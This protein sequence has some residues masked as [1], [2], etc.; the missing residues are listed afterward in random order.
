MSR[1]PERVAW[2]NAKGRCFNPKNPKY[3]R[4][5]SRGI[6]MCPQ[7]AQSFPTF[8]ADVGLKPSPRHSLERQ[9]N[10]GHYEPG[11]VVWALP[12]AQARNTRRNRLIEFKGKMRPLSE[13]AEMQGLS[14]D[15]LWSRI[16]RGWSLERA[17][18]PQDM[19]RLKMLTAFGKTLSQQDW[20]RELNLPRETIQSRLRRGWPLE[21][22][23]QAK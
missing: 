1:T 3:H 7:W 10:N 13:I 2:M 17:L 5:G 16:T 15:A 22:A 14:P 21:R 4:Y 20:A 6:T 11:N 18:S 23:L 19:S 8:L 9:N 12:K